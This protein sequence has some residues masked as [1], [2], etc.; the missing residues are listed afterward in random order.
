MTQCKIQTVG[1]AQCVTQCKIQ[2]VGLAKHLHVQCIDSTLFIW[3][4]NHILQTGEF[5]PH[6]LQGFIAR[7]TAEKMANEEFTAIHNLRAISAERIQM[8]L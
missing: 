5:S 3:H 6:T 4:L 2:T 7:V 8:C 1:L